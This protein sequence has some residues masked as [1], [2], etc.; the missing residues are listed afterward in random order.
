MTGQDSHSFSLQ[1]VPYV[2][3]VIVVPG[4]EQSARD[5]EPDRSHAAENVVVLIDVQ[6][7]VRSEVEESTRGVV[8]SGP[9][10]LAV[11]EESAR[12]LKMER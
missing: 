5:R 9:D 2:A 4:K 8:G 12:G 7:S 6:F 11:R 1:D 3:I 10:G